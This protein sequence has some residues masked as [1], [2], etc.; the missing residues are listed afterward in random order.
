MSTVS[1]FNASLSFRVLVENKLSQYLQLS[2]I[3]HIADLTYLNN[4]QLDDY[5]SQMLNAS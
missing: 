1:F 3:H 2:P 4:Q 5:I